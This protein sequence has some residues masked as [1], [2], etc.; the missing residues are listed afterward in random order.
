MCDTAKKLVPKRTEKEKVVQ[1]EGVAYQR[2]KQRKGS[3]FG[4]RAVRISPDSQGVGCRASGASFDEAVWRAVSLPWAGV[5]LGK[6]VAKGSF[7]DPFA[8]H[9]ILAAVE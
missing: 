1:L 2:L 7:G 4:E 8:G 9:E 3:R 6:T 5:L